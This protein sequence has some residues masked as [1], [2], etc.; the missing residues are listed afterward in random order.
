[1][2]FSEWLAEGRKDVPTRNDYRR[3]LAKWQGREER[4]GAWYVPFGKTDKGVLC[5]LIDERIIGRRLTYHI[6]SHFYECTSLNGRF[7]ADIYSN[8]VIDSKVLCQGKESYDFLQELFAF[9]L[10]FKDVKRIA[11]FIRNGSAKASIA[12]HNQNDLQRTKI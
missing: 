4:K 11:D 1:M 2:T 10:R 7:G 5:I 3:L 12:W 8:V 6:G 9:S